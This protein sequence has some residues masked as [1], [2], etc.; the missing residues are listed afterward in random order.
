[1]ND[2][3]EAKPVEDH[4]DDDDNENA[5]ISTTPTGP[6]EAD[7]TDDILQDIM[8]EGAPLRKKPR[9]DDIDINEI[10]LSYEEELENE[11]RKAG[12]R[13]ALVILAMMMILIP[14]FA[15]M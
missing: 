5:E 2:V 13:I 14:L 1:M 6:S 4:N 10:R 7:F 12:Q 8:D 11:R 3:T 15:T 9:L